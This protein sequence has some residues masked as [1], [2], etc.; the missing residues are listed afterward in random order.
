M[1]DIYRRMDEFFLFLH[2][3]ENKGKKWKYIETDTKLLSSFHNTKLHLTCRDDKLVTMDE[4]KVV[5]VRRMRK[6]ESNWNK[7]QIE[8]LFKLIPYQNMLM[9]M[10]SWKA[11]S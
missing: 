7:K 1:V 6:N 9:M 11:V 3:K 10:S 5:E 2:L 8:K 4:V